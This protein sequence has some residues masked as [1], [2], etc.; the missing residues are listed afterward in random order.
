MN[1]A[2]DYVYNN[3]DIIARYIE[4]NGVVSAIRNMRAMFEHDGS[5]YKDPKNDDLFQPGGMALPSRNPMGL[6]EAKMYVDWVWL[7][8]QQL[9]P[10]PQP[11][12][13]KYNDARAALAT[14]R[15][16]IA[17]VAQCRKNY[18]ALECVG[19]D[20]QSVYEEIHVAACSREDGWNRMCNYLCDTEG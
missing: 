12:V 13:E 2:V 5:R 16:S 14:L 9:N 1:D 18:D 8:H 10:K 11:T 3:C 20:L 19:L 17:R 7:R 15:V 4:E 6:R